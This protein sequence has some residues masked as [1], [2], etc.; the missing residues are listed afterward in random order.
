MIK[1]SV[2][3]LA[4]FC[5]AAFDL[6]LSQHTFPCRLSAAAY[7][8]KVPIGNFLQDISAC[9]FRADEGNADL[10]L[11]CLLAR[12]VEGGVGADLSL[13]G[14]RDGS[15]FNTIVSPGTEGCEG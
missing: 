5:G 8:V 9:L 1:R 6:D 10:H 13:V 12:G 11:H 15:R 3:N 4:L 2:K 14:S 7:R